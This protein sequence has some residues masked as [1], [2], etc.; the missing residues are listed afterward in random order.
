MGGVVLGFFFSNCYIVG[1]DGMTP[2]FSINQ[3][4]IFINLVALENQIEH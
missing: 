1:L 4:L 3:V 2:C